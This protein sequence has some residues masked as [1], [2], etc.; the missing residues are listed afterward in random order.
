MLYVP[1]IDQNLLS[2]GQLVEKGF[3]LLFKNKSCLIK[4]ANDKDILKV[5]MRG[6][7][8]ALNP[9]EEEK[10]AFPIKEN[11]S[12]ST[13]FEIE[14]PKS[15]SGAIEEK[16]KVIV[17]ELTNKLIQLSED[18]LREFFSGLWLERKMK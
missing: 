13:S 12:V 2:F 17:Q 11:V 8:F 7:F 10:I 6:N 1:E 18:A 4:D 14:A 9:L 3:K 16:S 5:K 15:R